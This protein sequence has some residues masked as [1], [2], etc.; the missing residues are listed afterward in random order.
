ML[1]T[2]IQAIKQFFGS[3]IKLAEMKALTP[4][5]KDELGKMACKELGTDWAPPK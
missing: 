1:M 3:G 2:S 5:D 4:Q